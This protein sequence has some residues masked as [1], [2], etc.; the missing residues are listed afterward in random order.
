MNIKAGI[1]K[2][3]SSL[4]RT[5]RGEVSTAYL[6]KHGLTIGRNFS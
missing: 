1:I 4:V 6:I 2:S 5:L 3:F